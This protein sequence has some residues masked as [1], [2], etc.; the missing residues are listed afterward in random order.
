LFIFCRQA[1]EKKTSS[2]ERKMAEVVRTETEDSGVDSEDDATGSELTKQRTVKVEPC[3]PQ[4]RD[5]M[6]T[7]SVADMQSRCA[8]VLN[9]K[10]DWTSL[11]AQ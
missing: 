2:G 8:S 1:E 6:R 3:V 4:V 7:L 9:E 11:L 10:M 5:S